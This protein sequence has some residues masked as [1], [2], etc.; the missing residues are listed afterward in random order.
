MNSLK[1]YKFFGLLLIPILLWLI[2]FEYAS[3][4]HTICIFKNITGTDCYGCG[5]MR[6]II[7]S[8]QF[9]WTLAYHYNALIIIVFPLLI[10]L[11]IKSILKNFQTIHS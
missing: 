8:V 1:K 5:I 6:A 3:Q 9:K 2:P 4:L 11:W 7:A 10:A